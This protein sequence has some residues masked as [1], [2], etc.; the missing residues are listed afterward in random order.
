MDVIKIDKSFIDDIETAQADRDIVK[1]IM[2]MTSS[3]GFQTLVEGI[4]KKEQ[5]DIVKEFGCG[6]AQGYYYGRP[7]NADE[8][9]EAHIGLSSSNP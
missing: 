7:I 8:F 5:A 2:A 3:L 6:Y 1:A 4:E 9:A